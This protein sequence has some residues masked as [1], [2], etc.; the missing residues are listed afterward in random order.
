MKI[1]KIINNLKKQNYNCFT[2]DYRA[3][4]NYSKDKEEILIMF[5]TKN[6]SL[7]EMY[8]NDTLIE[9]L[10]LNIINEKMKIYRE[11][12]EFLKIKDIDNKDVFLQVCILHINCKDFFKFLENK[13][14]SY[15]PLDSYIENFIKKIL[16]EYSSKILNVEVCKR[17]DS[18]KE[19]LKIKELFQMIYNKNYKKR[20]S[21]FNFLALEKKEIREIRNIL[22]TI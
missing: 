6:N 15:C 13:Y 16:N 2:S 21:F 11:N 10:E 7:L 8:L 18:N 19:S 9:N 5:E 3:E 22:N 14:N 1:K 12:F 17:V 20:N 4:M